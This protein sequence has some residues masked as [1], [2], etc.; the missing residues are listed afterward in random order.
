MVEGKGKKAASA[1]GGKAVTVVAKGV[2]YLQ[3]QKPANP[4]SQ[5]AKPKDWVTVHYQ[6]HLEGKTEHFDSSIKRGQ[7]FRFQL[8][9]GQVIQG[10]DLGVKGMRIGEK[11]KLIIQPEMGYGARGAGAAI[12]PNSTLVFEVE[13]L[14]IDAA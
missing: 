2:Q 9:V 8:G 14:K 7:P 10:W 3:L 4:K 6:G 13:L 11:R 5:P 1:D 12:P